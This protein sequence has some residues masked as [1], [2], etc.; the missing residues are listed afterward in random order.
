[1]NLY[2]RLFISFSYWEEHEEVET[3]YPRVIVKPHFIFIAGI[4]AKYLFSWF[5]CQQNILPSRD[6]ETPYLN[7]IEQVKLQVSRGKLFFKQ[8]LAASLNFT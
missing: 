2:S 4:S 3:F 8:F 1:M 6:A 5:K 7:G